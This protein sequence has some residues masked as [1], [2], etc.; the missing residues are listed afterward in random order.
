MRGTGKLAKGRQKVPI[1]SVQSESSLS[2][3]AARGSHQEQPGAAPLLRCISSCILYPVIFFLSTC[4]IAGAAKVSACYCIVRVVLVS[5]LSV[6]RFAVSVS[7]CFACIPY[8]HTR[9]FNAIFQRKFFKPFSVSQASHG[10]NGALNV[11]TLVS[12]ILILM[13]LTHAQSSGLLAGVLTP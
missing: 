1:K 2:L 3:G 7:V 8:T 9:F 11:P 5:A 12:P 10:P 13:I 4:L 6:S